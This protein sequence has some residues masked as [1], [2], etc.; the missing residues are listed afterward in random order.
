[1]NNNKSLVSAHQVYDMISSNLEISNSS[2]LEKIKLRKISFEDYI[3]N[4]I[5]FKNCIINELNADDLFYYE[6][7][8]FE[9]CI[10][11]KSSFYSSYFLA[12]CEFRECTFNNEVHFMD[13]GGENKA[14]NHII[15]TE[16]IF[17]G[18]VNFSDAWFHG[19]VE[20]SKCRFVQGTN[21]LGNI[22]QPY[23]VKF[24]ITPN[25]FENIGTLNLDIL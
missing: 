4:N 2:I 21:L 13:T 11:D 7:V 25:L 8:I 9:R 14:D 19:P 20:I 16:C 6:P 17:N 3:H 5:I 18:F 22:H 15:I 12:G 1:M 24:D 23:R 10:I